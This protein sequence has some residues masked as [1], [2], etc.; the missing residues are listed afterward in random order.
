[1]APIMT[2]SN[3]IGF[4]SIII[5]NVNSTYPKITDGSNIKNMTL[6]MA[7]KTD[8]IVPIKKTFGVSA[9]STIPNNKN[10]TS[11]LPPPHAGIS[12]QF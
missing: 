2:D 12:D 9:N 11:S 5:K 7:N 4:T 3:T 10:I 8:S 1:M 6:T